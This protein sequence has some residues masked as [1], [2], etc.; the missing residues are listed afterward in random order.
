MITFLSNICKVVFFGIGSIFYTH[1]FYNTKN[2]D[3]VASRH[4]FPKLSFVSVLED[5]SIKVA[6]DSSTL[7]Y[8]FVEIAGD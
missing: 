7:Q 3:F 5:S 6:K 2:T 1:W 4:S 8:M